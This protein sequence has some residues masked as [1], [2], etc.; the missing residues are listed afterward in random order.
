MSEPPDDALVRAGPFTLVPVFN[1]TNVGVD[2]NIFGRIVSQSQQGDVTAKVNPVASGWVRFAHARINFSTSFTYNY[3]KTYKKLREWDTDDSMRVEFPLRWITP[4]VSG[5]LTDTQQ[6]YS[7]EVDAPLRWRSSSL[8]GGISVSAIPRLTLTVFGEQDRL[9]YG[10]DLPLYF[11]VDLAQ[12]LNHDSEAEGVQIQYSL[13]PFTRIGIDGRHQRDLFDTAPDSNADNESFTPFVEFSPS[14]VISGRVSAGV[15]QRQYL[16]GALKDWSGWTA[17]VN[18][19]YI[20]LGQVRLAVDARRDLQYSF[21][22]FANQYVGTDV[23]LSVTERFGDSW[24]AAVI[25]GRGLVDYR[26]AGAAF[27]D[28]DI[29]RTNSGVGYRIGKTRAGLW[30]GY[31]VR[32]ISVPT[33]HREYDRLRIGV[34]LSHEF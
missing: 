25:L 22:T 15:Q 17:Q 34:N 33:R 27:P 30:I 4:F 14:A 26:E 28:E 29:W 10:R 8:I 11:G 19:S 24:D 3:F 2:S 32:S 6:P 21:I 31:E 18:L 20:L 5:S 12:A 1:M 13:T 16:T 7:L 23:S 9:E